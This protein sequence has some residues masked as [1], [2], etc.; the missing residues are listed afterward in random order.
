VGRPSLEVSF[1]TDPPLSH[2]AFQVDRFADEI[3]DLRPL[4]EL[5]GDVFR[6][7]MTQQ[8]A[9][10]GRHGSGGWA[11]LSPAYE[12]WKREHYPGRPIG[13]LTGSLRSAMTG[14]DGYSEQIGTTT[15]SFGMDASSPATPY[16]KY[17]D[18]RRPVIRIPQ[19]AVG[20]WRKACHEWL[21]A[22]TRSHPIG[23]PPVGG[24]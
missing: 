23:K 14:G 6:S 18:A 24:L 22:A 19:S 21:V 1:T 7:Q 13:V 12:K 3:A 20:E 17:F 8:F 9:S 16:G 15:A 10:E 2:L 5:F 4:M 11:A